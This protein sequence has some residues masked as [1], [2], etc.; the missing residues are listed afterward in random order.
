MS[1]AICGRCAATASHLAPQRRGRLPVDNALL[2]A[3]FV[4]TRTRH[5]KIQIYSSSIQTA[6][7]R[8]HATSSASGKRNRPKPSPPPNPTT[9]NARSSSSNARKPA[10][11]TPTVNAPVS[12]LPAELNLPPSPTTATETLPKKLSRFVAFGRAYLAFYKTG[13]KNVYY[14]YKDSLPIRR[15]LGLPAYIPT[16]PPPPEARG[17]N[18]PGATSFKTAIDALKI[19]RADFQ[20]VRRA[21]HDVRRMIPFGLLLI[22]CGEFTPLIVAAVGDSVTP[23]TC[24]IPRQIEKTR[25]KR[26]EQ[27]RCALKAVQGGLGSVKPIPPGSAEEMAWLAEQF[28]TR[29]FAST[30]SA[31]QVLR[32]CSTFGLAKSHDRPSFLVPFVYRPRLLRWAEYLDLDDR[33]IV[34]C[35][36]VRAMSAD[37]VRIAVDERGGA[38]VGSDLGLEAL[39]KEERR[40]L[41][42]WLARRKI[43]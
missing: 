36:G 24:R 10:S 17:G 19:S 15:A 9:P 43:T 6:I 23:F 18:S 41:S 27:K 29:E 40:W 3:H 12:T 14:N 35:G 32:A 38:G 11:L 22:I 2:S 42:E 21:A 34:S 39:E 13:L 25:I 28:G 20:L 8:R 26:V 7:T 4:L 33:L 5:S 37:E 1:S 31:E 16:S 30:A